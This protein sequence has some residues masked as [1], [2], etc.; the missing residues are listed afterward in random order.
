[1]QPTADVSV[2]IPVLD[3]ASFLDRCLRALDSQTVRPREIIVVD[4]GSSDAS[5]RV[6]QKH[7]A[8]VIHELETGIP[9][10][11]AAGYDGAQAAVIARLDADCVPPR[12]W[13]ERIDAA[14]AADAGLAALTGSASF[15]NGPRWLRRPLGAFY[16]SAYHA[17]ASSAL[18]HR[19]LFGSNMAL[20]SEVWREVRESVHRHDPR[21]H[22]DLD[23]AMHIGPKRRIV[24]DRDVRMGI[25]IRPLTGARS[26]GR[27]IVRGF[28]SVVTHWP[29]EVPPCRLA[30]RLRAVQLAVRS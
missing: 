2:V 23:L 20:R 29:R 4:N 15:S 16:L 21:V 12:D 8:L 25:D 11:S 7:G 19:P 30:R 13:I 5:A 22:D 28:W 14:F 3:D 27:R 6:A 17:A 1:M 9:A 24:Y 26:F 18:A 10:A